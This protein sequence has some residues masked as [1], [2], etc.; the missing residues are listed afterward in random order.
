MSGPI[1]AQL[2][3]LV[4]MKPEVREAKHAFSAYLECFK[5]GIGVAVKKKAGDEG[6]VLSLQ[7]QDFRSEFE[8]AIGELRDQLSPKVGD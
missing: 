3:L 6:D 5:K 7:L 8:K 2:R 4:G 1:F